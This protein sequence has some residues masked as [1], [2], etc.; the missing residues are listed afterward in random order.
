MQISEERL[1]EFLQAEVNFFAGQEAKS[2]SLR[3]VLDASTPELAAHLSHTEL[4][5]R[6]AQRILQ[7]EA[8][9]NWSQSA[10]LVE[11]HSLYSQ[12]FRELRLI[13]LEVHNLDSFTDVIDRLKGRMRGV[14]PNLATA[15][16]KLQQSDGYTEAK[17]GQW[18]D[19]FLLSRIS[20]E[21]LTSQHMACCRGRP[22]GATGKRRTGIVDDAC[23]PAM[24]CKQAA[25]H[26]QKVCRQ[27][28]SVDQDVPILVESNAARMGEGNERIRFPY[29]PQ[30]L[31]YIMVELLKN[32]TRATMEICGEDPV[33]IRERPIGITV[34][35]DPSQIAIRVDDVAGGIPWAVADHIWS[36]MYSTAPVP[37]NQ[38]GSSFSQP[39]T[40]L[41]GYGVGLPLSR[42]YARY[43]GGSLHVLSMPGIGTSA[44][45]YL[46]RLDTEAREELPN[47]IGLDFHSLSEP[48][49][50]GARVAL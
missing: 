48:L 2:I 44:Y 50:R 30:Y 8:L 21:M 36:Y 7:I 16:R 26:A 31:F 45:L 20:T 13:E 14:V 32:S 6:F 43:L 22:Q 18:L 49:R 29:V 10:E 5:I 23:D 40:P 46:Q 38:D 3:Q 15:M 47:D 12:A 19:T 24:I 33:A 27:H 1:Q 17:I 37:Q 39:G 34:G 41:A 35:A 25:K 4:P 11:V 28:Y 42:L 9:P